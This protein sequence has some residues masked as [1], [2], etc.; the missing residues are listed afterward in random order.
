MKVIDS[1]FNWLNKPYFFITENTFKLFL[2]VLLGVIA[3]LFLYF[4][5]PA[6]IK[7]LTN[8]FFLFALNSGFIVS[9]VFLIF[10]F[11]VIKVYPEYFNEE[12]WTVGKHI[13]SF[14][15]LIIIASFLNWKLNGYIDFTKNTNI[16]SYGGFINSLVGIAVFP[17]TIF[18]Y[19]DERIRRIKR[20]NVSKYIMNNRKIVLKKVLNPTIKQEVNLSINNK[21]TLKFSIN[22]LIYINS[23]KNYVRI[24]LKKDTGVQEHFVRK[25]M[26]ELEDKLNSFTNVIRCH[27]SYIINTQYI[28]NITG[29]ARGY[30]LQ[31]NGVNKEI[32]VSRKFKKQDLLNLLN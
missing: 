4:F 29:N 13:L 23:E 27:K 9:S 30:Y 22:D 1:I 26:L 6:S 12:T 19:F 2:S 8:N 11:I 28:K 31:F 7:L 18:L 15:I 21:E 32:P 20:E 3:F 5:A 17:I 14:S 16:V 25:Q 10:N 24:Y